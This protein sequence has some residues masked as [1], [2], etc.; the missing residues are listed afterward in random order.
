MS[1]TFKMFRSPALQLIKRRGL[2]TSAS[3]LDAPKALQNQNFN[4]N[5]YTIPLRRPTM[6]DLMEPYGSYKIAYAAEKKKA[7]KTL[8]L[9]IISFA[10]TLTFFIQSGVMDYLI[11]PNLD[12]IMEDTEPFDFGPKDDRVTV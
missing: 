8:L 12:N 7:N 10:A 9:G 3:C 4:P 1:V 2:K 6:D 5:N 11:M